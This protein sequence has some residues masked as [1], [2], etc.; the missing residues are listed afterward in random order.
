MKAMA[1]S[2]PGPPEVLHLQEVARPAPKDHEVLIKIHAT[3]ATA[4]DCEARRSRAP[5]GS[6]LLRPKQ[7]GI[8]ILGQELA[9]KVEAVGRNVARFRKGDQIVAW[10]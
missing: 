6:G 5:G 9:G 4:G 10:T 8:V 2:N 1:Y 3:T 7:A